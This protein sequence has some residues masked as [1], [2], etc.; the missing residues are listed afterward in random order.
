MSRQTAL[1]ELEKLLVEQAAPATIAAWIVALAEHPERYLSER[2]LGDYFGPAEVFGD[3]LEDISRR[4]DQILEESFGVILRGIVEDSAREWI[5]SVEG[6]TLARSL[7]RMLAKLQPSA[8]EEIDELLHQANEAADEEHRQCYK[9]VL[10]IRERMPAPPAWWE[11]EVARS[12]H[13]DVALLSYVREHGWSGVLYAASLPRE[14]FDA[15]L[16]SALLDEA[17]DHRS[18]LDAEF[19]E[20]IS[21]ALQ[22][23]GSIHVQAFRKALRR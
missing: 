19:E 17:R 15:T 12:P 3:V 22:V 20:R 8:K 2:E 9:I 21:D 5:H 14:R 1:K 6:R 13:Q 4:Y 23:H 18:L 11:A 16:F 10:A 7:L